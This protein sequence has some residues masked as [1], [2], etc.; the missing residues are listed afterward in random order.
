M[1]SILITAIVFMTVGVLLAGGTA[2]AQQERQESI[3]VIPLQHIS[4][5][6]AAQLFGGRLVPASPHQGTTAYGTRGQTGRGFGGYQ[7]HSQTSRGISSG[8]WNNSARGFDARSS[9]RR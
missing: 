3:V 1:K 5:A 2:L 4:A 9:Y 8:G 7:Q 6:T